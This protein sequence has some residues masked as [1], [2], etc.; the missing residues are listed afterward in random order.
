MK[1]KLLFLILSF[2][3]LQAL[4]AQCAGEPV[5]PE[6]SVQISG[7]SNSSVEVTWTNSSDANNYLLV[8]R[9]NNPVN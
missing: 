6:T 8:V 2:F 9:K 3:S 7:N 5:S 1:I 4:Q